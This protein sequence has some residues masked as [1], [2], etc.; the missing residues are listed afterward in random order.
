[1]GGFWPR[2]FVPVGPQSHFPL[3]NLPYGVF[4]P[5]VQE[6]AR[7]GVRI[8][9]MV[10]D[11]SVIENAGLL[12]GAE[13]PPGVF[14]RPVLN[15]F[16]AL[17]ADQRKAV[18]AA[19]QG[20]LHEDA[21]LLRDDPALSAQAL[22]QAAGVT[23][24]LPAAVGD[25]TDFYS[26]REHATNVGI[27]FRGKDNPLLPNWRHLPVGYHGRASS[28][29][30]SGTDVVRPCG[31]ALPAGSEVP[32]F[33]PSRQLDFELEVGFLVAGGNDQIGRAHV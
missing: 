27:M 33:G 25:Y 12:A 19:I 3:Q 13:L 31:Q 17:P 20:L 14:S 4:S 5:S 32:V 18:R 2:S 10:L 24:H 11:L 16:M 1:L 23:M 28:L 29:V 8:G 15:H 9:D 22:R 6:P 21:P 30:V 26:S 7:I